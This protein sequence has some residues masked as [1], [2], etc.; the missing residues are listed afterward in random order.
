MRLSEEGREV[1][2]CWMWLAERYPYVRLDQWIVVPD[3]M[4]GIIV[5]TDRADD[6]DG[7]DG[8]PHPRRGVSQNAPTDP[9]DDGT[10]R[11]PLGRLIGA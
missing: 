5:L 10:R 3:H 4:H 8:A 7:I 2:G 9:R 11:K 6:N 1:A